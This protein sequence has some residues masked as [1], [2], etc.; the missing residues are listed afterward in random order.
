M[1]DDRIDGTFLIGVERLTRAPDGTFAVDPSKI[2]DAV[3]LLRL[4]ML[5][6]PAD[7][8]VTFAP[9]GRAA[10]DPSCSVPAF[11]SAVPVNV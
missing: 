9:V 2:R 8:T 10:P 1:P 7:S 3:A 6:V 11:T 5:N 4:P